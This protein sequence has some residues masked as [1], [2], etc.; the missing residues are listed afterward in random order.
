VSH[1]YSSLEPKALETAALVAVRMGLVLKP[2]PNLHENDRAGFGFQRQDK[3]QQ[4]LR[5]FFEQ[6]SK[7]TIGKETATDARRR[8]TESVNDIRAEDQG[9]DAAIVA[10]GTVISL[11]VSHY[12]GVAPFDLWMRLGLP[13]YVVLDALAFT[14]SARFTILVL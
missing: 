9:R 2:R 12:N 14:S 13:S 1:L 7:L 3:L 5:R 8:F 11:F 6:P 4:R 10:H